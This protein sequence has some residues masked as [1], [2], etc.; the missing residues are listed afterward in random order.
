[1]SN[2]FNRSNNK[3]LCDWETLRTNAAEETGLF[4]SVFNKKDNLEQYLKIPRKISQEEIDAAL[5]LAHTMDN[6]DAV[7]QIFPYAATSG[8][9]AG[10]MCLIGSTYINNF[11]LFNDTSAWLKK[12]GE[13][14]LKKKD[15]R[16]HCLI[17]FSAFNHVD[18]AKE[19]L[20]SSKSTLKN[21][22]AVEDFCASLTIPAAQYGCL[23]LFELGLSVKKDYLKSTDDWNMRANL[24]R[25]L[26]TLSSVYTSKNGIEVV[27]QTPAHNEVFNWILNNYESKNFISVLQHSIY[28]KFNTDRLVEILKRCDENDILKCMQNYSNQRTS[29]PNSLQQAY[30]QLCSLRQKE[31]L[32]SHIN[33]TASSSTARK[34]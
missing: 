31:V 25:A 32:N 27:P 1:M 11:D 21:D 33:S 20:K 6:T 15:V 10:K 16:N 8:V 4:Q 30:E 23:E 18:K 28:Q 12:Y 29:H 9:Q 34:M 7:R 13:N 17:N 22:S 24:V 26:I 2:F 19:I 5:F 14:A 3:K